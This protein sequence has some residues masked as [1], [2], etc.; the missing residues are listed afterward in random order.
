MKSGLFT[1]FF[2]FISFSIFSQNLYFPPASGDDWDTLSPASLNWCQFKIDSLYNFLEKENTRSFILLKDGKIVLEKY[3]GSHNVNSLWYWASAGKTL[4]SF[5]VGLAQQE[6]YLDILEKTSGYLGNGWTS[7]ATDQEDRITI[8]NQL[9]MTSGLDDGVDDPYCTLKNCLIYKSDA[10]TRWAYHN[11]PYTLL[12]QVIE[13]ATGS[14]LNNYVI[15]KLSNKTGFSGLFLPSGYNN[16]FYST[17]RNMARFGLLILNKGN[18]NGTQIMTD[19]AYFHQMTHKSQEINEAYGYLWW[20]NG[21]SSFMVPQ[22]QF[23]FPGSFSPDAPADMI[24]ALG[25]NGQFL[26]VVPGKNLIWL[27]MGDAPDDSEVSFLLNNEIWKY[28]NNLGC[29]PSGIPM[30]SE[31]EMKV[32]MFPNPAS[33][34]FSVESNK[35]INKITIFSRTGYRQKTFTKVIRDMNISDLKP[36]FYFVQ[37]IGEDGSVKYKSLMVF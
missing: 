32:S 30:I 22:S 33:D 28:I 1:I 18:W 7:C 11:A 15:Q 2:F 8:R 14:N 20:L 27:R 10:G 21:S 16:V 24:A 37:I 23:K 26:N 17:A 19:S 9:T 31:I 3:F 35:G 34:N 29:D 36:G 5:M 13:K 4:T 12:D 25:K 6:G